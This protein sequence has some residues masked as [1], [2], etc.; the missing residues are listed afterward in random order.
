[1]VTNIFLAVSP[2]AKSMEDDNDGIALCVTGIV[3]LRNQKT[4]VHNKVIT[5]IC[6]QTE[7]PLPIG[8]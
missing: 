1:M 3:T 7:V 5:G 6:F 2:F 8:T 4:V